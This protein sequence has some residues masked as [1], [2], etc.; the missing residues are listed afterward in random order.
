MQPSQPVRGSAC[1]V[2]QRGGYFTG[3]SSIEV[4]IRTASVKLADPQ[5]IGFTIQGGPGTNDPSRMRY[6]NIPLRRLLLKA[7]GIALPPGVWSVVRFPP[8]KACI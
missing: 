8:A 1:G 2:A 6:F 7:Y 5:A 4:R 3:P